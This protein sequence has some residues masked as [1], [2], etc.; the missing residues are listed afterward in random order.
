MR[1]LLQYL[2]IA[3]LIMALPT[4]SRAADKIGVVSSDEVLQNSE[5]GKRAMNDLKVR[6]ESKEQELK[7]QSDEIKRLGDD[8]QKKSVTLSP[9]AKVKAQAEIETKGRKFMEDQQ[10]FAQ[11]FDADQKRVME[12]L[13][14]VFQQ[15]VS[16]YAKKNGFAL[17]VDKRATHFAGPGIDVTADITK[18]FDASAR[19]SK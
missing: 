9:E 16:D 2:L 7:R 5:A 15:V 4:L 11:Q 3:C 6:V 17:I 1:K 18:E 10:S 19:R 12:P 14:K 8:Y 13:F